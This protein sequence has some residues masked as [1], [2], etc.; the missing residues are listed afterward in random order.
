MGDTATEPAVPHAEYARM[1][2]HYIERT[3]RLMERAERAEELLLKLVDQHHRMLTPSRLHD[4]KNQHWPE[5]QCLTCSAVAE[6]LPEQAQVT[7]ERFREVAAR[8]A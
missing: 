4:P 6:L 5:C 2:S 1:K 3:E 7:L 8:D